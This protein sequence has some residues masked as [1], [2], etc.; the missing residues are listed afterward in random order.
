MKYKHNFVDVEKARL[1]QGEINTIIGQ[2]IITK[3]RPPR[4]KIVVRQP[5]VVRT[6]NR[7]VVTKQVPI[8]V[9]KVA[10]PLVTKK[11]PITRK[12]VEASVDL[13]ILRCSCNHF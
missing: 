10:T 2:S 1:L 3:F 6:V 5:L 7:P 8:V 9:R 4:P 13:F 12:F 11:V